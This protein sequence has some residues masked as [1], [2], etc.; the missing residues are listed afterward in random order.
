MEHVVEI[1][2]S[3]GFFLFAMLMFDGLEPMGR[4]FQS[5]W[6]GDVRQLKKENNYLRKELL[7]QQGAN[8]KALNARVETLEDIVTDEAYELDQ[9]LKEL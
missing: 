6:G 2:G 4:F 7:A 1:L 8:T 5:M 9:K 3:I